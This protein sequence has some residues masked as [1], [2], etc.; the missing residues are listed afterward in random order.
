MEEGQ[1]IINIS[2]VFLNKDESTYM[3][4]EFGSMGIIKKVEINGKKRE[5]KENRELIIK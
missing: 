4:L 1:L 3:V 5:F 2:G